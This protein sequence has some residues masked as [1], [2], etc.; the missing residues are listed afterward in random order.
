[1]ESARGNEIHHTAATYAAYCAMKQVPMDL[2]VFDIFSKGAG[3]VAARILSGMRETLKIDWQHLFATELPLSLDEDFRPTELVESLVGICSNSGKPAHYSGTLDNLYFFQDEHRA[4]ITDYKSH[5][6]PFDPSDT[7]QAKTYSLFVFSHFAWVQSINFTLIFVRYANV[8]KSVSYTR[9]DLPMLIEAV[10][11][12]RERQKMIHADYDAGKKLDA[13]AGNH[14]IYC[15]LLANAKCPIG[16]WNPQMQL[17][18]EQR[19]NFSLWYS[20]FSKANNKAMKEYV[21]ETGKPI[22]LKDFN[23][24]AYQFAPQESESE[25]YP[26]FKATATGIA[27]DAQNR[28]IMPVVDLLNDYAYAAP[29]DVAWMGKVQISST[30]LKSYLKT[31]R[32][33]VLDQAIEDITEKITK[34]KLA[35]SKPLDSLPEEVD[36]ESENESDF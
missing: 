5:P 2:A 7:L 23:G 20:A 17:T 28:L 19:L 8:S 12:G 30:S 1:M 32:R 31:K 4:D 26:L 6:R 27:V 24:K 29:D 22:T 21:Q 14:C 16:K 15:P 10:K 25:V 34:V 18:P 9:Q 36:D 35:V 33:T 13:V 11:A 3:S